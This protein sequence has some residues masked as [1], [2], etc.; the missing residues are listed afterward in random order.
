M[1]PP[2]RASTS[3]PYRTFFRDIRGVSIV[4]FAFC[5]PIVVIFVLWMTELTNYAITRQKVSQ[6]SLQ[7]ADNASRIGSQN[8]VQT[9]IDEKE[10]NDLFIGA[11]MQSGSLDVKDNGRIILSS[12][13]ID[14]SFPHGQYI[15]WQRCFGNLPYNSSYGAQG[16]G[17][18]TI[19][20]TGMGPPSARITATQTAPVMFVE[21]GYKYQPIISAKWAPSTSINEVATLIVRDNRD[22]SD[23]GVNPVNGVTPSTCSP[24]T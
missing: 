16:D 5:F 15:H 18:G 20:F 4:E 14:S 11:D 17:K 19:S 3:M 13:E 7:V 22:T 24:S 23:P 6:L 12:L 10:I 8:Q 21:V 9:V 2:R 1:T